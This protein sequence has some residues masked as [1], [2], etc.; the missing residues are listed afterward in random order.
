MDLTK[1]END[2]T[3]EEGETVNNFVKSGCPGL[4]V[5]AAD[6]Y[7]INQMFSL[8][9][10]GKTYTQISTSL[11]VKKR[12]VLYM[13]AKMKWYEKR[14]SYINDIQNAMTQKISH[15]RVQSINF[16]ADLINFH[17]KLYGEKIQ[18]YMATGDEDKIAN[19]DLKSLG[20]YFK[21][22]EMLEKVVN[23]GN[24]R[25]PPVKGG[26]TVNVNAPDGATVRA[27]DENTVEVTPSSS[28]D[29]LKALTKL[30]DKEKTKNS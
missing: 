24:I 12:L 2:F 29:I 23:P 28:A 4:A 15:T 25:T 5:L 20:Q 22:I 10:A 26:T 17:H 18:E 21:S 6:E 19:L 13:A 30:K 7:K 9:M 1:I 8:Y 14:M 11:G 27:L 16:I 3:P